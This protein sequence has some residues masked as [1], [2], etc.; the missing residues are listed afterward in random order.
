M[1]LQQPLLGMG[2]ADDMWRDRLGISVIART[3][4]TARKRVRE[5]HSPRQRLFNVRIA[6][7]RYSLARDLLEIAQSR[8]L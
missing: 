4:P 6:P 2:S 1:S 8:A 3:P 7:D 5:V